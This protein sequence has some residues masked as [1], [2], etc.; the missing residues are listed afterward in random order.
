MF[1]EKLRGLRLTHVEFVHDFVQL[2]FGEYTLTI[3]NPIVARIGDETL[4]SDHPD[5]QHALR[6]R[7]HD[8]VEGIAFQQNKSAELRFATDC[9]I[10]ILLTEADYSGP[11]AME[12]RCSSDRSALWVI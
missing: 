4:T 10:S 7:I 12:L 8:K 5:F 2:R 3:F 1:L 9:V 6:N 11:E